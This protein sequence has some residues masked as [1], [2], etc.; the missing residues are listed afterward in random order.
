[1]RE[2]KEAFFRRHAV[3]MYDAVTENCTLPLR[4]SEVVYDA[5]ERFPTLL[6]TRKQIDAERALKKQIAKEGLEIDQG[7]FIAHVLA[8]ERCGMHLVHAMLRPKREAEELLPEFRRTGRV[9]IGDTTVERKDNVGTVT[10]GNRAFLNAEDDGAMAAMETAVDLVLLDDRI[11]VGVLRGGL[12]QH[13]KYQ[14]KRIFNAGINLTHLYYGQISFIEF[15]MERELG[16]LNKIY[17]GHSNPDRRSDQLEDVVEKP[18]LAVVDSFAIGGGCQLLGVMDR[19]IAE[20]GAYFNLPASKEGFIPGSANLRLPRLTGIQQARHGIFFEKKFYAGTPEGT[21]ICDEVVEAADMDAAI[22]RNTKQMIAAGFTSTVS[23]RKALRV[24][25]EPWDVYRR[26]MAVYSR[27]QA[28]C[29]YDQA[30]ISN[31]EH[32]WQ[33]QKRRM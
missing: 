2:A 29:F 11:Q 19:V 6:P 8:D 33:P 26:Y 27:Q 24:G 21:L 20:P 18:W 25:Q 5:A 14:G 32:S 9:A 4:V 30:L 23:N 3:A 28:F 13:P 1:M 16:L 22:E 7:V 10:H 15:I 17:R 31:L 12:L